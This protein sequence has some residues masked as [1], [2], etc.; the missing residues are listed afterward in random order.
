M[1]SPDDSA[2]FLSHPGGVAAAPAGEGTPAE[3]YQD[4]GQLGTGG[5]GE[6]RVVHD[7][8]L[9]RQVA[10]K[11]PR[12]DVPGAVEA[13][14]REA[15][16]TAA[17]EHPGIVP[18]YDA[19]VGAD[20]QPWYTMRLVRGR[21]LRSI[22]AEIASL[23]G[24]LALLRPVL[25]A[26]E[27]VAYA[28]ARGV[29]HCDLKALNILLGEHGEVQVVDWGLAA[30]GP[31]S[32]TGGTPSS[33]APEQARGE[34]A[35]PA[36]DVWSLGMVLLEL[37]VGRPPE[38]GLSTGEL[39][40]RVAVGGGPDLPALAVPA[41]LQ[42]I[43]A[44]CLRAD[45]AAR[46]P[47]AAALAADLARFLDGRVVQAHDYTLADHLRRVVANH[48]L[49]F[50]VGALAL[51]VLL[52]V[53][54]TGALRIV[55][56]RDAA[57][58]A[59]GVVQ[60]ARALSDQNQ[61]RALVLGARTAAAA[62][63][64][65]EAEVLAAAALVL[66]ESPE[67][68]GVLAA[69]AAS[70][71]PARSPEEVPDCDGVRRSAAAGSLCIGR[72]SLAV[73]PRTG[74]PWS[75]ELA[76]EDAAFAGSAVVA[77]LRGNSAVVLDGRDG[78]ELGRVPELITAQGLVSGAD[79]AWQIAGRTLTRIDAGA[80]VFTYEPCGGEVLSG[81][82]ETDRGLV[83]VACG[84]RSLIRLDPGKGRSEPLL[85]DLRDPQATVR[86]LAAGPDGSL[87]VGTDRGQVLIHAGD[88]ERASADLGVAVTGLSWTG[89]G[90][91]LLVS[92]R[93]GS[94]VI[95]HVATGAPLGRLPAR[96]GDVVSWSG[97]SGLIF[98]G[99][100]GERWELAGLRPA[101]VGE[102]AGITGLAIGADE[103]VVVTR[104]DG[105]VDRYDQAGGARLGHVD[106]TG[107]PLKGVARIPG[108]GGFAVGGIEGG[109]RDLGPTLGKDEPL[110]DLP[111]RRL[112]ALGGRLLA[113]RCAGP[114][115]LVTPGD[116]DVLLLPLMGPPWFDAGA[117][118][119]GASVAALDQD[120]GLWLLAAEGDPRRLGTFPDAAAADATSAGGAVVGER[121]ALVVVAPD[122]AFQRFEREAG[123]VVDL[124]VS[125]DD[126]LV[127]LGGIDGVIRIL[128]LRSGRLRA[129]LEGHRERVSSLVWTSPVRLLSGSWDGTVRAWD[130]RD[131]ATPAAALAAEVERAWGLDVAD[132]LAAVGP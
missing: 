95:L 72:G 19:G 45:P 24:R 106:G 44:R 125:P 46:Y 100:G 73:R 9:G 84:P 57:R 123:A 128:E 47:D 118:D 97:P 23:P 130:L 58:A 91:R 31:G 124:A 74:P 15:S 78:A 96:V 89:D 18:I 59:E 87:A 39:R 38:E 28:H 53:V 37:V 10:R 2:P 82:A 29:A 80:R 77:T 61:A 90:R 85:L 14:S 64:R 26:V 49:A 114:A 3:R 40:A 55:Q 117:D 92:L 48:R 11:S 7:G 8:R 67:A 62:G 121:E 88:A 41:A 115:S 131:S 104:G 33:M 30:S 17:L 54:S 76:A 99:V 13:L 22:L 75:I 5:M 50:G 6:V 83:F 109:V 69:F 66:E 60:A 98:G 68:R 71:R 36:S 93:R 27:A 16:V 112:L 111:A 43:V 86:V 52:V 119:A 12:S 81:V 63:Q 79:A 56:E 94:P 120:G 110:A 25:A 51:T 20:G 116:P 65:P 35:T 129:V 34:P 4:L 21:T 101:A 42:A 102:G 132:A 105:S 103:D 1:K 32:P 107:R 126:R 122:G 127:A 113:L 108:T 70:P